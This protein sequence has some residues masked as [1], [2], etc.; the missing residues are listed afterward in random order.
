MLCFNKN[1]R[2]SLSVAS[3]RYPVVQ[4]ISKL[5]MIKQIRMNN[6][7]KQRKDASRRAPGSH[8]TTSAR[9]QADVRR[10]WGSKP[11]HP[12][13]HNQRSAIWHLGRDTQSLACQI[14]PSIYSTP[15]SSMS[16]VCSASQTT[17]EVT[18]TTRHVVTLP[19][20]TDYSRRYDRQPWHETIAND[21][22]KE[23]LLRDSGTRGALEALKWGREAAEQIIITSCKHWPS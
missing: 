7:R 22:E 10:G 23:T 16:T 3:V 17:S 13:W 2:D 18:M 12:L 15:C 6:E 5:H 11:L 9:S 20:E 21:T 14:F 8:D 19:T 1:N 4:I